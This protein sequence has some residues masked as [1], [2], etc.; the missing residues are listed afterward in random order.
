MHDFVRFLLQLLERSLIFAIPA[1]LVGVLIMV[2]IRKRWLRQGRTF[3]WWK[4]AALFLLLGWALVTIYVT[5]IRLTPAGYR[6]TNFQLFL[7]WREAWNRFTP[8]VWL[9]V[10]L[11]IGLFVPFGCLLPI[12]LRWARSWHG[13]LICGFLTSLGIESVQLLLN[14][15][16]FDVD[17]LFTNTLGAMLGWSFTMLLSSVRN[18]NP[19]WGRRLA[20]YLSVPVLFAAAMA[21]LFGS[22][23]LQPYGNLPESSVSTADL[24][25]VSWES[26][27][28]LT[29][30]QN[31]VPVYQ[32]EKR[33]A[34]EF[35]EEFAKLRG[36]T[37]PNRYVYDNLIAFSNHSTG[38]FLHFFPR[39]G[40]W[41]YSVGNEKV[42]SFDMTARSVT[43]EALRQELADWG[44]SIPENA[45]VQ[46]ETIGSDSMDVIFTTP[47]QS[48]KPNL[49]YGDLRCGL[50]E[51][52][53]KTT[54]ERVENHLVQL[55]PYQEEAVISPQQAFEV[56]QVG[57]SFYGAILK[58]SLERERTDTV[59]V[60]SCALDWKV[61]TKGFYQ[62]VYRFELQIGSQVQT[63]DFVSALA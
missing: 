34:E 60:I 10:F 54:L 63:S 44:V 8:Q 12:V 13:M 49:L 30:E 55:I 53:G 58:N 20:G 48:G 4:A 1:L 6:V 15:G 56:L 41:D 57:N 43:P 42:V 33:D 62:P 36:I 52:N 14:R 28:V 16:I 37:F 11:N 61:D 51:Q 19:G 45:L 5:V 31:P 24:S 17:D 38:D 26:D 32:V 25:G 50:Y 2:F 47:K 21:V 35:A 23:A 29:D 3:S 39:D 46:T 27:V 59:K 40:I 18:R 9:N 7:A 22:Y